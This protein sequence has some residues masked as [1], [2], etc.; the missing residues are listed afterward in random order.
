MGRCLDWVLMAQAQAV[1]VRQC[2][3]CASGLILM[4]N[5]LPKLVCTPSSN[6]QDLLVPEEPGTELVISY[7][8]QKLTKSKPIRDIILLGEGGGRGFY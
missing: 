4:R 7:F 6:S 1:H 3:G 5:G 2:P 8:H